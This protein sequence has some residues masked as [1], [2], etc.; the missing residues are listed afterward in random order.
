M[1]T[2]SKIKNQRFYQILQSF[3]EDES[4]FINLDSA[5][6]VAMG[7]AAAIALGK[8]FQP[9]MDVFQ[10]IGENMTPPNI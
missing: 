5:F 10:I 6:I 3:V 9:V 1:F 4:G 8:T 7:S 2:S